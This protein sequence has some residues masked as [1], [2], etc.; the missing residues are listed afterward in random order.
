MTRSTHI[1]RRQAV[2]A[3]TATAAASMLPFASRAQSAAGNEI[4]VG[5]SI[6]LSGPLAGTVTN[7]I[8]GQNLAIEGINKKGGINGRPLRLITMDDAYDAKRC[9]ENS[10]KMIEEDNVTALFAPASTAGVGALLPLIVEKKIPLIGTYSGAHVVR[11]KHNPYFFTTTASYKDEVV[12]M[13]KNLVTLQRGNVALVYQNNAFGQLMTPVVEEAAKEA[14]ATL[15]AKAP[16]DISGSDAVTT[17]QTIGAAKPQAVVFMAFG[18]SLVAFVKAARN[19]VG[20]PIYC[21]S[22][23]NSQPL[24]AALGDDARGLAFTQVIPYPWRAT[25]ALTRDFNAAVAAANI[26]VGYDSF[27]GYLNI[28]VLA[29]GLKRAG[30]NVTPQSVVTGM[31]SMRKTDIG[32]YVLDYSPT[33]HHGS[34]FVEITIVGPGGRFMR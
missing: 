15:V 27:I 33:N 2:G 34:K 22:V 11:L 7:V 1:T 26:P 4:V 23:S 17:A 10:K 14:G 12:Q 5:Q 16:L 31:E 9:Y 29:E 25:T 28:R 3:L 21:I 20:A 19:Y 8:K 13:M 32:G 24:I 30:K 6:H 18:P